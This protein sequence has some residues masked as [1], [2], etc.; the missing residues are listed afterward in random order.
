[1]I[2]YLRT[3]TYLALLVFLLCLP[4]MMYGCALLQIQE[5]PVKTIKLSQLMW[6]GQVVGIEVPAKYGDFSLDPSYSFSATMG[7][8]ITLLEWVSDKNHVIH[9]MFV[10]TECPKPIALR[11]YSHIDKNVDDWIIEYWIY[12]GLRPIKSTE[13]Q[14]NII[15]NKEPVCA[16]QERKM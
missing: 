5:Q 15:I 16:V 1:M 9:Q 4:L 10:A 2:K 12:E 11:S 7:H 13:T 8:K 3:F 14:V 6:R